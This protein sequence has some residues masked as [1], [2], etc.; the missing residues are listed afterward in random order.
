MA[1]IQKKYKTKLN[2]KFPVVILEVDLD[3]NCDKYAKDI[4]SLLNGTHKL[5]SA[6]KHT[7]HETCLSKLLSTYFAFIV[8]RGMILI[9]ECKNI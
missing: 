8:K 9:E 2:L 6:K 1:A 7:K 4:T 5:I 3:L